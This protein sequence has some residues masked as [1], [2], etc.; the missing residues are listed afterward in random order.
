VLIRSSPAILRLRRRD[1]A[2]LKR[3]V[4]VAVVIVALMIAVK[5]GR[6]LRTAGLTGTCSVAQATYGLSELVACTAGKLE[7]RPDLSHRGCRRGR[8]VGKYEYWGCPIG[9]DVSDLAR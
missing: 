1:A 3:V 4:V 7:G 6:V 2:V 5:D 8:I 9:F